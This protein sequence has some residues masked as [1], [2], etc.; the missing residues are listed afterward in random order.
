MRSGAR[1][2]RVASRSDRDSGQPHREQY[3]R[4]AILIALND[5]EKL[6]QGSARSFHGDDL[7]AASVSVRASRSRSV[8]TRPQLT[9]S[10][11]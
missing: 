8:G 4:P 2:R 9:A 5:A 1:Q 7:H 6:G 10:S 3:E 11:S